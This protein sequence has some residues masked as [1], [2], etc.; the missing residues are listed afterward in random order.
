MKSIRTRKDGYL[1]VSVLVYGLI[2]A[3]LIGGIITWTGSNIR[4]SRDNITREKAFEIAEAG[5]EYYRWHLAHDP[6]DFTDGTGASGP[7]V[8][9]Y[10]NKLGEQIGQFTLDI[11]SPATGTT[12]VTVQSTGETLLEPNKKRAI[13]AR[14]AIPS[15]AKYA[16]AAN[17]NMRFGEG[18]EVFGLIHSNQ[19]VR[20]DGLTHNLVTSALTQYDDPDHSGCDDW[21]VHTHLTTTDPCPAT[22][23]NNRP[24]VF[25]VGRQVGVPALDFAGFTADLATMR[26]DA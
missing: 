10:Y 9:L 8:H 1:L 22:P 5:I 7:Y 18:T 16:V 26:T 19:G 17:D 12:I 21:A 11:T 4:A 2:G 15:L 14:L 13:E 24:D 3:I 25:E 6:L 23:W 20:F